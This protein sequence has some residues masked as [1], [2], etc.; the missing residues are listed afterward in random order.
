MST[1]VTWS[2]DGTTIDLIANDPLEQAP[3]TEVTLTCVLED[4]T[5]YETIRDYVDSATGQHLY[6]GYTAAGVWVAERD[7][8][9]PVSSHIVTLEPT[10]SQPSE[11]RG[12][13]IGILG[14]EIVS[15][16]SADSGHNTIE[17]EVVVL[18]DINDYD[19]VDALKNDLGTDP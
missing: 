4:T 3:G 16:P 13:W 6:W 2:L 18:A 9:K 14:G 17:L 5:R 8:N 7:V 11:Y 10:G 1:D 12:Y 15:R 19:T